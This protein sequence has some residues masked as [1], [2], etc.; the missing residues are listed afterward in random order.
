GSCVFVGDGCCPR[1][2]GGK[3]AWMPAIGAP[4]LRFRRAVPFVA[5]WPYW[6]AQRGHAVVVLFAVL[7]YLVLLVLAG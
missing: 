5:A 2:S 7:P 4:G 6:L 1:V 3:Q